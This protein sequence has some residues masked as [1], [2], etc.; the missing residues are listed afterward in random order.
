MGRLRR[1]VA[2]PPPV[3][4]VNQ[5]THVMEAMIATE[6]AAAAATA[7]TVPHLVYQGLFEFRKN[8]PPE[9]TKVDR[10][11][12]AKQWIRDICVRNLGLSV[13]DLGCEFVVST[14]TLSSIKTSIV[15]VRGP[16]VVEGRRYKVNLICIPMSGLDVILGMDLLTANHVLIDYEI[17][18]SLQSIL[19][20]QEFPKIFSEDIPRIPLHKEVE[21]AID[22]IPGAEPMSVA[23]YRM[24]SKELMVLKEQIEDVM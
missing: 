16:I 11:D 19:V 9:F 12:A 15:C 22:L 20:V 4:D 21:F 6:A 18:Q 2:N 8:D 10:P 23:S 14:P 17:E 3:A 24:A 7:S 1:S 13:S 5:M